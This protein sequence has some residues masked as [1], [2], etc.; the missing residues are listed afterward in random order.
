VSTTVSVQRGVQALFLL[1]KQVPTS[2]DWFVNLE[3][4]LS[5][6]YWQALEQFFFSQ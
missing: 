6:E 1:Q 3:E 4:I 5:T 2:G